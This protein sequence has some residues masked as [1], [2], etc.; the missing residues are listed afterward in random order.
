MATVEKYVPT[1]WINETT[2][3]D[4]YK[5]NHIEQQLENSQKAENLL[6]GIIIRDRLPVA[7]Q[8]ERGAIT[9]S[10][11]LNNSNYVDGVA[12]T[13]KAIYDLK[14][15]SAV[16][17]NNDDGSRV[18][19]K[20]AIADRLQN[21]V[22]INLTTGVTGTV[23]F[24]S[25]GTYSLNATVV[26]SKHRHTYEQIES[27]AKASTPGIVYSFS[28]PSETPENPNTYDVPNIAYIR[29]AV[30][31]LTASINN[32]QT[33]A[34]TNRDNLNKVLSL[35]PSYVT[36]FTALG[37]WKASVD[38]LL[39]WKERD[40]AKYKTEIQNNLNSLRKKDEELL[41]LIGSTKLRLETS[42]A[43][44]DSAAKQNAIN[45]QSLTT[46]ATEDRKLL[47]RVDYMTLELKQVQIRQSAL[48]EQMKTQINKLEQGLL[49]LAD[50]LKVSEDI[51]FAPRPNSD[52]QE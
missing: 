8:T 38:N 12:A 20:A 27:Y 11:S 1:R 48:I 43:S 15:N 32:A 52:E 30:S 19:K 9:L 4:E 29:S 6:S 41:Q 42:I 17:V 2:P 24:N 39:V 10:N 31:D 44:V 5:M 18:A 47:N 21:E 23:T 22:R 14:M 46:S 36:N 37:Q 7:N 13:P 26:P 35:N 34:N 25:G 51:L 45:I 40:F 49:N 50:Y 16:V 33:L 28:S 3:I